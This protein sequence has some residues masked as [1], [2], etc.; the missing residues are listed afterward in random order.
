MKVSAA[1][2]LLIIA[3]RMR[4]ALR[5]PMGRGKRRPIAARNGMPWAAP[6]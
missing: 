1:T 6:K 3:F 5:S 4:S 2:A